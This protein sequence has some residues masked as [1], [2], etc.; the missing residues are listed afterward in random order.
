MQGVCSD[1]CVGVSVWCV[2]M[3]VSIRVCACVGVHVCV[4]MCA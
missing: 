3:L 1:K 4:D 2:C